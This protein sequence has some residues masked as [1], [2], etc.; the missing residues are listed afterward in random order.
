MIFA[1]FLGL[2]QLL[3][4]MQ[5]WVYRVWQKYLTI[6]QHSCEWNCWPGEFVLECP[7]SETQS[8]SVG[9][10]RWSVEHQ[11]F[12][13]GDIFQ[14]QRLCHCDSGYFVSTSIF[15]GMSVP[16]RNT[17]SSED[18]SGARCT[19]RNQGQ[20]WILVAMHYRN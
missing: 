4:N 1:P 3:I 6:W 16:S 9:I 14:K 8:I 11:A 5:E 10:E 2:S 15:I 13:C 7:F 12:C 18:I 19:K 17:S 20:R